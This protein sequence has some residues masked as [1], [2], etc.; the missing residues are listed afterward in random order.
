M[1]VNRVLGGQIMIE[2][3]QP[4]SAADL[5]D[6]SVADLVRQVTE[7]VPQLV[8][9]ELALAKAELT[10]KG[11]RAG[12][13]A[14]LFGGGGALALYGLGALI[15]AA[16]LGLAEVLPGW[17]AALIVAVLLFVVAGV[18]GLVARS[19]VR[20]AVPPVPEQAVQSARLDVEAV[21]ESAHR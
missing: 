17:L 1:R 12:F 15:A 7:L 9:G 2:Q 4:A 5:Q 14:G 8:R 18:L 11:K 3:E 13:G 10:E 6:R 19:Q 20:R 21:K 16:V